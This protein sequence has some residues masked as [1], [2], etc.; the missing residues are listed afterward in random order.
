MLIP[1]RLASRPGREGSVTFGDSWQYNCR[2]T[3]SHRST[4]RYSVECEETLT[5]PLM[6]VKKHLR[7]TGVP[8]EVRAVGR[9]VPWRQGRDH[10]RQL[11]PHE[12]L[13]LARMSGVRCVLA[14]WHQTMGLAGKLC[15]Q[16]AAAWQPELDTQ[17]DGNT[18]HQRRLLRLRG[19]GEAGSVSSSSRVNMKLISVGQFS[20]YM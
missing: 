12:R 4:S 1:G 20:K 7:P 14:V 8:K 16:K 10:P 13:L 2:N 19:G 18:G 3:L 15:W 11:K 6:P 9:R 17:W 5:Q